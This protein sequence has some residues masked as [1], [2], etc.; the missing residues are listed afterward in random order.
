MLCSAPGV[1]VYSHDW[2][3]DQ[4]TEWI[5]GSVANSVIISHSDG[6]DV[7]FDSVISNSDNYPL[8]YSILVDARW[9][10]YEWL[11]ISTLSGQVFG[12]SV[13]TL[14]VSVLQTVNLYVDTYNGWLYITTNI[15]Y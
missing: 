6:T 11:N 13:D 2:E 5:S 3:F 7:S 4:Q 9:V 15:R 14:T 12:N 1:V 10:T 8:D